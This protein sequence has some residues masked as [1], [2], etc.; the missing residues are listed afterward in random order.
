MV[1]VPG[2]EPCGVRKGVGPF[3][4]CVVK[5]RLAVERIIPSGLRRETSPEVSGARVD[6]TLASSSGPSDEGA[7]QA[8]RQRASANVEARHR[9]KGC[10]GAPFSKACA[11]R[12]REERWLLPSWD[13]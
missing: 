13:P 7:T 1:S 6:P 9:S 5:Y 4:S 11:K 12:K 2:D 3:E 8:P 10:M